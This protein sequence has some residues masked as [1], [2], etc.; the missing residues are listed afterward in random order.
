LSYLAPFWSYG[1]FYVLLTLLLFHPKFG[2]VPIAPDR[3]RW[4]STSAWA[5]S[6]SAVKLFSK[7]S[8]ICDHGT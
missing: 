3:P 4:A 5:L 1:T 8:N 6:Y 7:Y 2:G